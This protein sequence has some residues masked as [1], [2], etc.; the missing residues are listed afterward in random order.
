MTNPYIPHPAMRGFPFGLGKILPFSPNSVNSTPPRAFA[1]PNSDIWWCEIL[2]GLLQMGGNAMRSLILVTILCLTSTPAF[3]CV[4]D[5]E[6]KL[7]GTTCVDGNC[8][9]DLLS[10]S[11][12][13]V[14]A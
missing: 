8:S 9:R 1:C 14:P 4:F 3:A 6:C 13:N 5:T 7:P 11:D 2:E 10:G 12:D